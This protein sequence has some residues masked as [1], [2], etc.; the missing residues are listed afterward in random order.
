VLFEAASIL[1]EE[2]RGGGGSFW[3][4]VRAMLGDCLG[5]KGVEDFFEFWGV[6]VDAKSREAMEGLR[7]KRKRS[8]SKGD[9]KSKRLAPNGCNV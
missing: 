4:T 8:E 1:E 6:R 7:R 2:Q 3:V 9:A 5:G